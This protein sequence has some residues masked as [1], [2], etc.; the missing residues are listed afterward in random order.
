MAPAD[1][2]TTPEEAFAL[3]GNETRLAILRAL[4]EAD[5][6]VSF[7]ELRERVGL[8][9][10]A[11]FNY[12]LSKLIGHFVEKTSAGY[13]LRRSGERVVEAVLSGAVE[14]GP[15]LEPTAVDYPCHFCNAS[16]EVSYTDGQFA[17]HCPGCGGNSPKRSPTSAGAETHGNLA[18]IPFPPAGMT[19]RDPLEALRAAATWIHLAGLALSS[20]VCP[21]CAAGVNLSVDAC[22]DHKTD[23][24]RCPRCEN[25]HAVRVRYECP[26]CTYGAEFVGLMGVIASPEL[27]AFAGSH[28]YN[29]TSNGL[30]WGW[31]YEEEV[32]STDPFSARFSVTIDGDTLELTV[33]QSFDVVEAS[34]S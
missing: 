29:T 16:I 17:L 26:N 1:E 8:R 34:Q 6:P 22:P 32:L 2:P 9:Q 12:H 11:Q 31:G 23:E 33:N 13:T 7:T 10:G 30:D 25:R 27:Q 21:G 14:T 4:G 3:L 15:T 20:D 19:G 28:G 24:G 5:A 18:I